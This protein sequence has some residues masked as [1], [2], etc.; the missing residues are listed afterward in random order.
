MMVLHVEC[1]TLF[2]SECNQSKAAYYYSI[3]E[4][5]PNLVFMIGSG[6]QTEGFPHKITPPQF[7]IGASSCERGDVTRAAVG[8]GWGPRVQASTKESA[9]PV[10]P[11]K[12]ISRFTLAQMAPAALTPGSYFL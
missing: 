3:Y 7:F 8:K 2:V 5:H 12:A 4:P 6:F 9:F 1:N 10:I 11:L